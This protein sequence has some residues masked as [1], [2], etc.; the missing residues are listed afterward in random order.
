MPGT[1]RST[2]LEHVLRDVQTDRGSLLQG[3]LFRLQF[4]TATLAHRCRR[5]RP[6][7]HP[8]QSFAVVVGD[9]NFGDSQKNGKPLP[10]AR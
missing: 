9:G 8:F 2:Q 4:D 5:R 10:C 3:R 7:H 1:I 6:P